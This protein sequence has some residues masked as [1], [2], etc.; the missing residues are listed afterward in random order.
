MDVRYRLAGGGRRSLLGRGPAGYGVLRSPT[1]KRFVAALALIMTVTGAS[2]GHA[3]S[4]T[5]ERAHAKT[6]YEMTVDLDFN[7]KALSQ[8]Q[9]AMANDDLKRCA[10]P[11]FAAG[12]GGI[13]A[14]R[15]SQGVRMRARAPSY[16]LLDRS[17]RGVLG[18]FSISNVPRGKSTAKSRYAQYVKETR[19]H[20][21]A[22]IAATTAM[23]CFPMAM[24]P[25]SS[26][27]RA[28]RRW[29]PIPEVP[30]RCS[31]RKRNRCGNR[32]L[33][34]ICRLKGCPLRFTFPP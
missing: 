32:A 24:P 17:L 12:D 10:H 13:T 2:L 26:I 25:S 5:T 21:K 27:S 15:F 8:A 31:I 3:A 19:T 22:A 9:L 1:M 7:A 34:L 28:G 18:T 23:T 20:I 30:P 6:I 33:A 11:N 4:S 16:K 14:Q 29:A